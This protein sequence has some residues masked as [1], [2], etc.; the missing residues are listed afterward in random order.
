MERAACAASMAFVVAAAA[1]KAWP[2]KAAGTAAREEGPLEK[3]GRR[4]C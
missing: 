1:G 3:R 2:L 4:G